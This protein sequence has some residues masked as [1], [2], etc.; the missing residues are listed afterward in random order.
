V[1]LLP[2]VH[3]RDDNSVGLLLACGYVAPTIWGPERRRRA[4]SSPTLL[5]AWIPTTVL[6]LGPTSADRWSTEMA[7]CSTSCCSA[8]HQRRDL[9]SS[10]GHVVANRYRFATPGGVGLASGRPSGPAP[11]GRS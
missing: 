2:P 1:Q 9:L 7:I 11:R 8:S 5:P 10:D 3:G 6:S 4:P